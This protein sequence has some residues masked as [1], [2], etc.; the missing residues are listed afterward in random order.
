[1]YETLK[2]QSKTIEECYQKIRATYG[3][4]FIVM[5]ESKVPVRKLFWTHE[6]VE[7][8]FYIPPQ[9]PDVLK[10]KPKTTNTEDEKQKILDAAQK[11]TGSDPKMQEVLSKLD[12][13]NIKIDDQNRAAQTRTQG[14]HEN[15]LRIDEILESNGFMP[16]YRRKILEQAK[17]DL[18]LEDIEN[19]FELQQR[20]IEWIGESI[21]IYDPEA[22]YHKLPRIII[23]VGPTGV[24]KTTTI[25]KL[26][27]SFVVGAKQRV[28]LITIDQYRIGAVEQ[29][30]EYAKALEAPFASAGD[31]DELKKCLALQSEDV[32]IIL[33]DTIG[34]SPRDAREIGS[35]KDFLSVCTSKAEIHLA[36][37]AAT[38]AADILEITQ[39]FEPFA[40]KS[41]IVTKFDETG[42]AGNVISALAE[43]GKRI[44][45]I[46]DGQE[47]TPKTLQKAD[48][49]RFLINLE[50]FE[51]DRARLERRF[52]KN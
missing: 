37:M 30:H 40:Y 48:V 17:R 32:D 47:S 51:T 19:F 18:S 28:S 36:L 10:T 33:I 35:M 20:V 34:R 3:D 39:Q 23:L 27:A 44:S 45:Y 11:I 29:L 5:R 15:L 31:S 22:E 14:E 7:L 8:Q 42:G 13:L 25:A 6:E 50:G 1:M 2:V 49:I 12:A 9:T 4:R 16:S 21:S 52:E 41:V 38:K 24:G 46:T 26:A 43:K